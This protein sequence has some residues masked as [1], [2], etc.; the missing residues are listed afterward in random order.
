MTSL[1]DMRSFVEVIGLGG[2]GRAAHRLGISKSILS[3]RITAME[4][5]LGVRLLTRSRR[6]VTPTD[7][8]IEWFSRCERI[9]AEVSE[10]REVVA[11]K[12]GDMTGRLR[13][14]APQSFGLRH[15]APVLTH[16]ACRYPRL[17]ID[18]DF[19]DRVVDL[20]SEGYDIAVRIGDPRDTSLIA[21][22]IAPVRAILAASPAYLER[23]GKPQEPADLLSHECLLYT[24]GSASE[25]RLRAGR[26]WISLH[27]YGRLRSAN[28]EAVLGWAKE[29]LGICNVP[30]FL[31][32]EELASGALEQV[33]AD[34]PQPEYS[35]YILRPP[36]AH[37]P[38]KVRVVIDALI[39][40]FEGQSE[41]TL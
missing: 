24:G 39:A 11:G 20:V 12:A 2:I 17:E 9:L 15:V 37:L 21:R 14:T 25:W 41:V 29:G 26:K 31:I 34:Y 18:A 23:A 5:D 22:R 16:M 36:G 30:R 38:A 40:R 8:G 1:D 13:I 28:G 19:S 32:Q 3:R 7:A 33:L 6:G 27:P 4:E 10:A 35:V